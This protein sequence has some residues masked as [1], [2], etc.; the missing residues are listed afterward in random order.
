MHA[1]ALPASALASRFAQCVDSLAALT[2]VALTQLV[3]PALRAGAEIPHDAAESALVETPQSIPARRDDLYFRTAHIKATL[4]RA[5]LI[6]AR[7][8]LQSA[9]FDGQ[10][11]KLS[12]EST[13][14]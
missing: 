3:V 6:F 4:R 13:I 10:L 2:L 8:T 14:C 12:A 11:A 5:F 9:I 7:S 1:S